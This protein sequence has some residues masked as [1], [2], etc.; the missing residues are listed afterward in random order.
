[1]ILYN[2]T[3]KDLLR[4]R[5]IKAYLQPSFKDHLIISKVSLTPK[6]SISQKNIFILLLIILIMFTIYL[7]HPTNTLLIDHNKIFKPHLSE[8]YRGLS[9]LDNIFESDKIKKGIKNFQTNYWK[10]T[11]DKDDEWVMSFFIIKDNKKEMREILLSPF[12]LS[13]KIIEILGRQE[14]YN[15]DKYRIYYD[16]TIE[17]FTLFLKEMKSDFLGDNE[18]DSILLINYDY[19]YIIYNIYCR[20]NNIIQTVQNIKSGIKIRDDIFEN[21]ENHIIKSVSDYLI[22]IDKSEEIKSSFLLVLSESIKKIIYNANLEW[23]EYID[24]KISI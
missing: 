8:L 7:V 24:N 9:Y 19:I 23:K 17:K 10:I 13:D 5:N 1:M 12:K 22:S 2:S 16:G 21:L 15:R 14:R 11:Y 3:R 20:I 4:L 18:T 6:F